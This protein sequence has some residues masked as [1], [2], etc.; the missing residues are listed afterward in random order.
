[1]KTQLNYNMIN[2]KFFCGKVLFMF[3]MFFF[4]SVVFNFV[5]LKDIIN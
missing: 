2:F 3:L 4:S 1:M 5:E